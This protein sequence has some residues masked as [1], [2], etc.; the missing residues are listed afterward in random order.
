MRQAPRDSGIEVAQVPTSCG[1]RVPGEPCLSGGRLPQGLQA[2][3]RGCSQVR[4]V[5]AGPT[6]SRCGRSR[7]AGAA[8]PR[9]RCGSRAG[10]RVAL[11]AWQRGG[12]SGPPRRPQLLPERPPATAM[13]CVAAPGPCPCVPP[14]ADSLP[15]RGVRIALAPGVVVSSLSPETQAAPL[16]P[17]GPHGFAGGAPATGAPGPA[18]CRVVSGSPGGQ[19][20]PPPQSGSGSVPLPPLHGTGRSWA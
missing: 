3:G 8:S 6:G 7:G 15:L 20:C 14:V 12:V 10:S 9:G 4:Q 11:C 13:L 19:R 5:Q 16:R 17:H 2:V 1:P 18:D